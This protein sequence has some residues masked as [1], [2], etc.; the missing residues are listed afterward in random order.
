MIRTLSLAAGTLI[1]AMTLVVT[2]AQAAGTG[3]KAS[4][5]SKEINAAVAD[6]ARPQADRDR[7]AEVERERDRDADDLDR[8]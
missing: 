7:D 8:P 3:S 5:V 2:D 1:A 4:P 6:P